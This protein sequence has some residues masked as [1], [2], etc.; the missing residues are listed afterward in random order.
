[1][2]DLGQRVRTVIEIKADPRRRFKSMEELTEIKAKKWQ[3]L[4]A[5]LQQPTAEMLEAIG[6][7]WPEYSLWLLTGTTDEARGQT[8]P[9]LERIQQDLKRAGKA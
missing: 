1:M 9:V 2:E 4:E 8:S 5:G 6:N 7:K 3:N